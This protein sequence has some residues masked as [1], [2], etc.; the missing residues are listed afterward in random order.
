MPLE[1]TASAIGLA[2][3]AIDFDI[4][5]ITPKPNSSEP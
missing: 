4:G 2:W 3:S 5:E 1:K